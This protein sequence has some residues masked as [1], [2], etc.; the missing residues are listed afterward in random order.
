MTQRIETLRTLNSEAAI[1]SLPVVDAEAVFT[2]R[3][4]VHMAN[5]NFGEEL[6]IIELIHL[7]NMRFLS[8]DPEKAPIDHNY[9][10]WPLFVAGQ[11]FATSMLNSLFC[12][13]F[14]HSGILKMFESL[15][16]RHINNA[17]P[18][19]NNPSLNPGIREELVFTQEITLTAILHMK[20]SSLD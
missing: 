15:A 1:D 4:A 20:E 8:L 18:H 16:H 14:F 11:V 13:V 9:H 6:P 19:L 2:Y 10:T 12:H 17:I 5:Q 3:E 7:P